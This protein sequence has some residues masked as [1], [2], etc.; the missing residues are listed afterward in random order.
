MD[1]EGGARELFQQFA[2]PMAATQVEIP[3]CSGLSTETFGG[4]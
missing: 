3:Y 2:T 1:G 4:I